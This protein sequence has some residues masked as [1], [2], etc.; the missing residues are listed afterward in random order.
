M[1][2]LEEESLMA[3][4]VRRFRTIPQGV[5][6]A[7]AR[8]IPQTSAPLTSLKDTMAK[9]KEAKVV[10]HGEEKPPKVVG[11][12]NRTLFTVAGVTKEI[13]SAPPDAPL[14]VRLMLETA[15]PVAWGFLQSL[16][17]VTSGVGRLLVQNIE[18]EIWLPEATRLYIT[19]DSVQRIGFTVE[20]FPFLAEI[21]GILR[22]LKGR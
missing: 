12:I 17:P 10:A 11:A 21:I 18:Q 19:S 22:S 13:L 8:S 14:H 5:I 9:A 2:P 1:V 15:G 16:G 7:G 6:Q 3:D 20:P 4:E